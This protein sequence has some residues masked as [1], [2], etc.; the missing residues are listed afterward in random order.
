LHGGE[1]PERVD[2]IDARFPGFRERLSGYAFF[3]EQLMPEQ[4]VEGTD[5]SV[6]VAYGWYSPD[7]DEIPSEDYEKKALG[8]AREI[9]AC[10]RDEGFEPDWD[11]KLNRKIGL[12]L[13]WQRRKMLE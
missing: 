9:C 4:L 11:G 13:N 6:Y 10:L 12:A 3:I 2:V 1:L 8:I 7:G 5:V